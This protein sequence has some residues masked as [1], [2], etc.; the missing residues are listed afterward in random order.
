MRCLRGDHDAQCRS[1]SSALSGCF[2]F[3]PATGYASVGAPLRRRRCA[4]GSSIERRDLALK[5]VGRFGQRYP[6]G[7]ER[8]RLIV[9][10]RHVSAGSAISAI[11]VRR[12]GYRKAASFEGAGAVH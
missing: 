5:P 11:L 7:F 1:K 6:S 8:L 10:M 3:T 4:S 2:S 9:S 12:Q